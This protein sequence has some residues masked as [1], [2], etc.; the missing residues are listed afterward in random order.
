M[1]LHC[2]LLSVRKVGSNLLKAENFSSGIQKQLSLH[3]S[4]LSATHL[5]HYYGDSPST[6]LVDAC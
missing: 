2:S 1:L 5:N 3:A 4:K 6:E